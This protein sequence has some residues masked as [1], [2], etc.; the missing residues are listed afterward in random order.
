MRQHL[1]RRQTIRTTAGS[2]VMPAAAK[3]TTLAPRVM[4]AALLLTALALLPPGWAQT[5]VPLIDVEFYRIHAEIDPLADDARAYAERLAAAGNEVEL[6]CARRMIHGYLRARFS[7]AGAAAEFAR[8]CRFL[9]E[10][11]VE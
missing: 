8:P 2:G 7:G 9:R 4:L 6:R 1:M 10:R 5:Q 11:L 3:T